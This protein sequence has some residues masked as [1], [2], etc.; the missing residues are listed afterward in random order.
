MKKSEIKKATDNALIVDFV[1]TN[2]LWVANMY[3]GHA[4]QRLEQ[5]FHDLAEELV[6]RGI[7]TEEDI[8]RIEGK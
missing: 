2:Q 1:E 6:K 3:T 5:H 7:L 4:T 8:K